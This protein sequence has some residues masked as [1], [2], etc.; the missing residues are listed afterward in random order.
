MIA[1]PDILIN[2]NVEEREF[3]NILNSVVWLL[4]KNQPQ[5]L[6]INCV[7]L[8]KKLAVF[9]ICSVY[10]KL[11]KYHKNDRYKMNCKNIIPNQFDIDSSFYYS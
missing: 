4:D 1:L 11:L 2:L 9:D 5:I 3:N 8:F 10:V 7:N 6:Q